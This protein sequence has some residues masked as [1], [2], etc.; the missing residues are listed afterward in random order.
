[1]LLPLLETVGESSISFAAARCG[2][3]CRLAESAGKVDISHRLSTA[4]RHLIAFFS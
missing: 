2:I 1:M 3:L 4:I